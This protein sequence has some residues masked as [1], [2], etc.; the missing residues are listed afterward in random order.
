MLRILQAASVLLLLSIF[1]AY[2]L[3][4]MVDWVRRRARFLPRHRP[5]PRGVV[6]AAFYL[7]LSAGAFLA[8]SASAES[9][10]H[11]VHVSAP[12]AIDRLFSGTDIGPRR[13]D[14]PHT[15]YVAP[16]ARPGP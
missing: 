9:I 16:G 12:A 3:A 1:L 14:A 11:A 5:P 2:V 7:V 6:I 13:S 10:R 15:I 8:W 4:P